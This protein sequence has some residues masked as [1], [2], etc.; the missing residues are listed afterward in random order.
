MTNSG[1]LRVYSRGGKQ[2]K[3]MFAEFLN[4]FNVEIWK[5]NHYIPLY[6]TH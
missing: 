6:K 1:V 3:F 2:K 5:L 4:L